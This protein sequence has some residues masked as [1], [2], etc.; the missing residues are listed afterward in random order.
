MR[1]VLVDHARKRVGKKRGAAVVHVP[2]DMSQPAAPVELDSILEV[3]RALQA[4]EKEDARRA[5]VVEMRFFGGLTAE[6]AALALGV[7]VETVQRD[8]RL[9]RAWLLRQLSEGGDE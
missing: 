5:K 8:W 3:H 7:S 1:Q 2:L 6:D 9:A 4:L